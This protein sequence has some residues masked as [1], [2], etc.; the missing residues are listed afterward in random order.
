M[1]EF[2]GHM[3]A[4]LLF[5]LRNAVDKYMHAATLLE[6]AMAGVGTKDQLLVARVVR[7]HWDRQAMENIKGAYRQKYKRSLASR[8]KGETSGDYERLMVVCVGE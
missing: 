2:S 5:Q 8:I 6:D 4:A 7:Y 3:E 1:Q